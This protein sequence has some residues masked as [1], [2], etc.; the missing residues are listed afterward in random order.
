MISL[1]VIFFYLFLAIT[2]PLFLWKVCGKKFKRWACVFAV[3]GGMYGLTQ[4][5]YG[6]E[7]VIKAKYSFNYKGQPYSKSFRTLVKSS[8]IMA[9]LEPLKLWARGRE[10]FTIPLHDGS[11]VYVENMFPGTYV[12]RYGASTAELIKKDSV[13]T[14]PFRWIWIDD[15]ENPKLLKKYNL[16]SRDYPEKSQ[17]AV[18]LRNRRSS[19][20]LLDGVDKNSVRVLDNKKSLENLVIASSFFTGQP[21]QEEGQFFV[22]LEAA[23]LSSSK[24]GFIRRYNGW[25]V[26]G[27]GCRFLFPA[28]TQHRNEVLNNKLL[29][30]SKYKK[31][32]IE[33]SPV[34][35]NGFLH[36]DEGVAVRK[37]MSFLFRVDNSTEVFDI[38]KK[39]K[40]KK[41]YVDLTKAITN[42][43]SKGKKCKMPSWPSGEKAVYIEFDN[44]W[45]YFV[46]RR[47]GW[48]LLRN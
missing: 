33:I 43:I 16:T 27:G 6:S 40:S 39:L 14:G 44:D 13:D 17:Q 22:T 15:P 28:Q 30:E 19:V 3:L 45:M 18:N 48:A 29:S 23:R 8:Y 37:G 21:A 20:H 7:Y 12:S 35:K 5:D 4:L 11:A 24:A 36:V 10:G 34:V 42:I 1:F 26:Q 25:Q 46:V 38:N 2:M 31:N 41:R 47:S 9:G 32:L